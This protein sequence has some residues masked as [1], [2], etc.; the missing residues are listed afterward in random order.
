[1]Q[2]LVQSFVTHCKVATA[3]QIGVCSHRCIQGEKAMSTPWNEGEAVRAAGRNLRAM[4][5][6]KEGPV[7][8]DEMPGLWPVW[9]A[10]VGAKAPGDAGWLPKVTRGSKS[11]D[12]LQWVQASRL[13]MALARMKDLPVWQ[14]ETEGR[15]QV[16]AMQR[17]KLGFPL[18]EEWRGD[19]DKLQEWFRTSAPAPLKA[20]EWRVEGGR[21]VREGGALDWPDY[22]PKEALCYANDGFDQMVSLV[23]LVDAGARA[24]DDKLV[25]SFS[26][27]SIGDLSATEL[28]NLLEAK[29][30]LASS[31]AAAGR[32]LG[33]FDSVDA[34]MASDDP[35]KPPEIAKPTE[36]PPEKSLVDLF[37]LMQ[38]RM[39][40]MDER[41]EAYKLRESVEPERRMGR[42]GGVRKVD[43][44]GGASKGFEG[45]FRVESEDDEDDEEK[46][47]EPALDAASL[48]VKGRLMAAVMTGSVGVA[49]GSKT[50][51]ERQMEDRVDRLHRE[52]VRNK[53]SGP[54]NDF[55]TQLNYTMEEYCG[56][57]VRLVRLETLCHL[58]DL[59]NEEVRALKSK[60]EG[61][62]SDIVALRRKRDVLQS[63]AVL[64]DS[65][66]CETA[67]EMYR[68]YLEEERGYL[69]NPEVEKLKKKARKQL[70]QEEGLRTLR[71]MS[72]QQKTQDDLVSMQREQMAMQQKWA[73]S[74]SMQASGGSG[75]GRR[76][77][78]E[79]EGDGGSKRRRED[80]RRTE[81][82]TNNQS[83][84]KMRWVSGDVYG[85]DSAIEAPAPNMFSK[86]EDL[87]MDAPGTKGLVNNGNTRFPCAF[88]EKNLGHQMTECPAKQWDVGG[89]RRV[90]FRW[91]FENGKCNGRGQPI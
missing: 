19:L 7:P 44:G 38:K 29:K 22:G 34:E 18:G 1:L 21:P 78:S 66:D 42:G 11:P 68:L 39:N 60:E 32:K 12:E 90:N 71:H 56:L 45:R 74:M 58:G 88:C 48:S 52:L 5:L 15:W 61:I 13:A 89:K 69:L 55:E 73:S 79:E 9:N 26:E 77:A 86:R 59:S 50:L 87:A 80:N 81:E 3:D 33:L 25:G 10:A 20:Q 84:F 24:E 30:R 41:M 54:K 40:K 4:L 14:A 46:D 6:A 43:R 63:C 36:T 83:R 65:G 37:L 57:E 27:R 75:R 51:E 16:L 49:K 23:S 47:E 72:A 53:V 35:E 82:I 17:V 76:V 67:D 2:T 85:L 31:A 62:H 91:L 8:V 28:L 70:K 64:K